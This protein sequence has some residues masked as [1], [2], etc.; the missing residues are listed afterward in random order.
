MTDSTLEI[1]PGVYVNRHG[2]V[3]YIVKGIAENPDTNAMAVVYTLQKKVGPAKELFRDVGRFIH[4]LRTNGFERHSE[5]EPGLD[6][7]PGSIFD[8]LV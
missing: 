3:A 1:K 7:P 8:K 4:D 5:I 2:D 6:S